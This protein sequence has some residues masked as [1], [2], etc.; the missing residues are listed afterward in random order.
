MSM[1]ENFPYTNLHN[2]NLDW[3][4]KIA[5][6]FLD[7][8][9]HIQELIDNGI[10]SID[11]KTQESLQALENEKDRLE[12]LLDDWYTTH[13]NDIADQLATALT[14]FGTYASN[15]QTTVLF[16]IET[17]GRETLAS[18]PEDYT[19]L[20]NAISGIVHH[21]EFVN[22]HEAQTFDVPVGCTCAFI[23]SNG[24]I[25]MQSNFRYTPIGGNQFYTLNTLPNKNE[26]LLT[27]IGC[28]QLQLGG[29]VNSGYIIWFNDKITANKFTVYGVMSVNN[30][31]N[32]LSNANSCILNKLYRIY[33]NNSNGWPANMP[34]S[35]TAPTSG[36][37]LTTKYIW[38]EQV[39]SSTTL[40][41]INQV[42]MND[43]FKALYQRTKSGDAWGDWAEIGKQLYIVE[44][45]TSLATTLLN[46]RTKKDVTIILLP[47]VHD[48]VAELGDLGTYGVGLHVG[49]GLHIKGYPGSVIYCHYSGNDQTI[50]QEFSPFFVDPS[51]FTLEDV[52][53][54]CAN[55]RY[56]VH[57]DTS[58]VGSY[59][60]RYINCKMKIDNT[61]PNNQWGPHQA[62]GGGFG[63]HCVIEVTGGIYESVGGTDS[64]WG[65]VTYHQPSSTDTTFQNKLIV[66][67]A[68]F[69]TH[70]VR[71]F[72]LG[73]SQLMSDIIVSG[74]SF[75]AA[76][77]VGRG[78]GAPYD[79]VQLFAWNNEIR[80]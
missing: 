33:A 17:K 44:S 72:S 13:S 16:N 62:I 54:D 50:M 60:H 52:E 37:L 65:T 12:G 14:D 9:T 24:D 80:T 38:G 11:E 75:K 40:E 3:M 41:Y 64:Q 5:K 77:Y 56:C 26:A 42:Y 74:C 23:H 4:I 21:D 70:G 1:F 29:Y 36:Y 58:G 69:V 15:V 68:Y 28:T 45:S 19:E 34:F 73:S 66:K 18:I 49:N 8:Y 53:I 6:D 32:K 10:V 61:D 48:L 39:G 57:D 47:G 31:P 79:N 55:V 71:A 59:T 43:S 27:D 63:K 22:S 7:Q 51:D 67:D 30:E 2:L 46:V 78:T 35:Y 76:P 25:Q 20:S